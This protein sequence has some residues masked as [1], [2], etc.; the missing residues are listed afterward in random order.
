MNKE[1]DRARYTRDIKIDLG[2][3]WYCVKIEEKKT[4]DDMIKQIDKLTK[5][6]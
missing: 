2:A 3:L 1:L 6:P 4:V 5:T